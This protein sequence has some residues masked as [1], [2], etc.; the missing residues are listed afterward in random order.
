MNKIYK[1]KLDNYRE[2]IDR[3]DS[4]LTYTLGERFKK[5][6]E[7]GKIKAKNNLPSTDKNRELKQLKRILKIAKEINLDTVFAKK[8]FSLIVN[9]VKNNHNKMKK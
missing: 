1:E 4:I 2:S 3:L 8:F 7:I 6:N 5:T 9:E